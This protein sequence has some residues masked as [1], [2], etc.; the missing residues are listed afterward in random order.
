MNPLYPPM[1]CRVPF[2]AADE[3]T[4]FIAFSDEKEYTFDELPERHHT[5]GVE[6]YQAPGEEPLYGKEAALANIRDVMGR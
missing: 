5:V 1:F 2:N 6:A 3:D 4:V